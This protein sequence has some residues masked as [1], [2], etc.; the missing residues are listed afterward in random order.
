MYPHYPKKAL[1]FLTAFFI[2]IHLNAQESFKIEDIL[3]A[4]F[5]TNLVASP[6]GDQ[7][8][9]V[10][11]AEGERNIWIASGPKFQGK[12]ITQYKGDNGQDIS[13]LSF[14]PDGKNLIYVRGGAPNRQGEI[15]N[16][17]SFSDKMDRS[18]SI[19]PASELRLDALAEGS[20][21][22]IA[23]DGK[24][25][26]YTSRGQVYYISF[27]KDAKS[28]QLFQIRGSANGVSW[29][30]DGRKI[31]F[32]SS[33][34]DHSFVG[35]YELGKE[36]ILWVDP[37]IDHDRN[38]VWSP[39]GSKIA[40]MRVPYTGNRV[41][42]LP[43]REGHPWSLRVADANTGKSTEIWKAYPGPG[44]VYR[45]ISAASQIFWGKG[46]FIV[47]P[48]ER[49]SWTH[50]YS[51]P[52]QGGQSTCLTPGEFEVQYVSISPDGLEMLYSGNQDDI[53]RQHVWQVSVVG[54]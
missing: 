8:A 3:S 12:P 9:W 2:F 50:L 17:R 22:Q 11:N 20:S 23:P 27:E 1:L 15:P 35:I 33:R 16:P 6:T 21:P 34:G 52:A 44:S 48:W 13:D 39:D 28:K 4:P 10:F 36:E 25:I 26:A 41:P 18:I 53:D 30:P 40:F 51:V 47:F 14:S 29:S 37:S 46:D 32:S 42:F 24:G 7:F 43:D 49:D 19:I 45:S 5:P 54:G 31:A 38:P